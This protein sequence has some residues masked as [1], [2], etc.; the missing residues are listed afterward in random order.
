MNGHGTAQGFG[1]RSK[2]RI[3]IVIEKND[4]VGTLATVIIRN[5]ELQI[6]SI[7]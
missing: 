3:R 2:D 7:P 4:G 1:I 5:G 6:I